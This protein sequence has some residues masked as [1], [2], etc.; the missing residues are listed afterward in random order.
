[1]SRPTDWMPLADADP[2]PGDP[3]E[4]ALTGARLTQVADQINSDV[5]W[6]RSL[7]TAQ[8]W[9]SGA[10]QAF[11]A[12]VDDA[13]AKLARA[14]ERYL[15]AGQALGTSATGPSGYAAALDQAQA[16]SLRARTQG[17]AAWSAMR[18]QLAAVEVANKGIVPYQGANLAQTLYPAQPLLDSSGHPVLMFAP[19]TA[20]TPLHAAVSRYNAGALDYRTATGW[21][22]EAIETRDAAAARAA[23]AIRAAL[24]DDGLQDQTGLWHDITSAADASFGWAEQHWAQVVGDIANVCGWIA[25][26]LGVLALIFAFICPPIAAALEGMALTLTEVALVCHLI[27]AA[28][29]KGS[30]LDIGLDVV[31]IATL[32]WGRILLRGGEATVEIADEISMEGVAARA[33]SLSEALRSGQGAV[34]DINAIVTKA[35]SAA[36][37]AVTEEGS[38]LGLPGFLG[39]FTERAVLDFSPVNPVTAIK[40]MRTTDWENVLGEQPVKAITDAVKQTIL[41][42]SPEFINVKTELSEIPDVARITKLTGINFTGAITHY[43]HLWIGDQVTSLAM[44]AVGKTDSILNYFRID[45]PG[46][47]RAKEFLTP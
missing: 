29:G 5:A 35:N 43:N 37:E 42:K 31:G 14:H 7:C 26:A 17:Q 45:F 8:F 13:A 40:T 25:S 20:S 3:V 33:D 38:K 41:M 46:F 4:V 6:L 10:G 16:L 24:G 23:A 44:D 34:G 19:A 27:L 2:V 39:K 28:F 32:G 9:D 47:D 21:L 11:Q 30:L 1:V 15:A 22:T 18:T 12:Q 36:D